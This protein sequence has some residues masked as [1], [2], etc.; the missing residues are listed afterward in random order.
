MFVTQVT[1]QCGAPGTAIP[2]TYRSSGT[3]PVRGISSADVCFEAA[4]QVGGGDVALT[5]SRS[6]ALGGS[7][8]DCSAT[9]NT[10]LNK[11]QC[12]GLQPVN[13]AKS[14]EECRAACCAAGPFA[15]GTW[16]WNPDYDGFNICPPDCTQCWMGPG[17]CKQM[18]NPAGKNWTGQMRSPVPMRNATVS[19]TTLPP[20]CSIVSVPGKT[21]TVFYN[22]NAASKGECGAGSGRGK[23]VGT[24][25]SIITFTLGLDPSVPGGLATITLSGPSEVWFGVGLG[26]QSMKDQPN[27]IIV[28]PAQIFEQRLADQAAGAKIDTSVT[29]VSNTVVNGIRTVVLSRPFKGKSKEHYTFDAKQPSFNFINAVGTSG[30][31]AYHKQRAA[32]VLH[33]AAAGGGAT[34]VCDA[35]TR[36]YISSDMNPYPAPLNKNCLKEPYGDLIRLKNPTCTLEQYSGG[37]FCCRSGNI[38]LDKDQ[39]PWEDNILSYYMKFRFWFQEYNNGMNVS[40][41]A[42]AQRKLEGKDD[43]TQATHQNLVR[44]YHDGGGAGEYD[45]VKA[46]EGTPPNQTI[47]QITTHLQ[48]KDGVA[49]CNARTSPHC[50]G[51]AKSG[52]A[53]I[54]ASCHCH[55]PSCTK[56]ELW[57]DDTEEMICRQIPHYGKSM[58][59]AKDP[60]DEVGYVAIPPCLF[61]YDDPTLPTPHYLSYDTNLTMIK[62]NNNTYGHY[63]DMDMWQMRGYQAYD[64]T[65]TTLPR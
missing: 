26:A 38:L 43:T 34:C 62:W 10:T 30:K 45:I 36:G 21:T 23:L 16:M 47:Y 53:L 57:N 42:M 17:S 31:F 14:K 9:L 7:L 12:A 22:T 13:S 54:Y 18:P 46:P 1:K 56:C 58:A 11:I 59:T 61:S 37:L 6:P 64:P 63:G 33:L 49:M 24:A 20:G 4:R 29:V 48:V 44:F 2:C 51:P 65:A 41:A 27:A 15:C 52:I 8:G 35:G 5:L 39:N 25:S 40:A 19:S 50:A 32:A 3:C 60:Y 55:A 28:T